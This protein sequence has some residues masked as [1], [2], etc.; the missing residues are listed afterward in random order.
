MCTPKT[1]AVVFSFA[2]CAVAGACSAGTLHFVAENTYAPFVFRNQLTGAN[3]G[4]EIDLMR[5]V[6]SHLGEALVISNLGFDSTLAGL[7]KGSIDIGGSAIS[8]TDAR[9]KRVNF[10]EPYYQSGNTILINKA[11]EK[12]IRDVDDLAGATVCVQTGTTGAERARKIPGVSLRQ[13]STIDQAYIAL[14]NRRCQAVIADRPVTAY[15]MN[16]SASNREI[17]THLPQILNPELYGFA[18]TKT[19]P[20]LV[21]RIN[22]ALS[23]MHRNGEFQKIY[24]KWFGK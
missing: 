19:K 3:D 20:K 8:I 24:E 9:K 16:T 2:A 17:F 11:S 5:A 14:Y 1:A 12:S 18:V 15:F 10:T 21:E 13:F 7:E 22:N 23:L 6:A 4:F